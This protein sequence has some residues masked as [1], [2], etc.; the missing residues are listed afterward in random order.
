[1]QHLERALLPGV[2]GADLTGE[3]ENDRNN[4]SKGNGASDVTNNNGH[5]HDISN[6]YGNI[7]SLTLRARRSLRQQQEQ[8]QRPVGQVGTTATTIMV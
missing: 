3:V 7:S 2:G 1:M 8:R 4:E 5:T 6:N